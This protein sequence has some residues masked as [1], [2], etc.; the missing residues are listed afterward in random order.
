MDIKAKIEE[1]VAKVKS[2]P[3]FASDFQKEPVKAVEK[4]L[5]V[6]LPD[7]VINNIIDG[8]KA[9]VNVDGLKDKLGGLFGGLK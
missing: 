1:V 5:G 3:N 6:D 9:K 8:V 2:D 4:V 7:D